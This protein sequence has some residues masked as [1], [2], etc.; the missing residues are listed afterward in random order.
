M[1]CSSIAFLATAHSHANAAVSSAGISVLP[2][3]IVECTAFHSVR[4]STFHTTLYMSHEHSAMEITWNKELRA[5]PDACYF[6]F[7]F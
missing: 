7:I 1:L 4:N 3:L 6:T 5:N 2:D